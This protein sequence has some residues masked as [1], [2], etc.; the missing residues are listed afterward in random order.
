MDKSA[1]IAGYNITE[2]PS[3]LLKKLISQ[4]GDEHKTTSTVNPG[5]PV[6]CYYSPQQKSW[7]EVSFG[8]EGKNLSEPSILATK[9]PICSKSHIPKKILANLRTSGGIGLGDSKSNILKAYG[10]PDYLGTSSNPSFGREVLSYFGTLWTLDF[11]ITN[12]K[13]ISIMAAPKAP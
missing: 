5:E 6:Y 13:V 8:H 12:N 10:K 3:V 9:K 1:S 11:Y 7:F 2:N 4:Y